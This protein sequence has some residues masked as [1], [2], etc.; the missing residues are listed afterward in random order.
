MKHE[1]VTEAVKATP[2]ISGAS[3]A[4]ITLNEWV[5]GITIFYICVQIMVLLHKHYYFVKEKRAEK[6]EHKK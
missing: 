3:Y 5:A 6:D 2:A 4:S 1:V